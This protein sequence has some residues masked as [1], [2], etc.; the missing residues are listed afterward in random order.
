MRPEETFHFDQ[1]RKFASIIRER[2]GVKATRDGM[3][4]G[5]V[6]W[7]GDDKSFDSMVIPD[8][9]LSSSK[10]EPSRSKL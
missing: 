6:T 5:V 7:D 4:G 2:V 3:Y 1:I 9:E 10:L 8:L